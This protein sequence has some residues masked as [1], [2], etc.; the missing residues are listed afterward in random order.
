[1]PREKDV[2]LSD[3]TPCAA[4][5]W[6]NSGQP[7]STLFNDV[8]FSRTSGIK[9]K[10]Y[11]FLDGNN[12]TERIKRLSAT[13]K[14]FV[15]GETGFGT[16][17]NFLCAWQHFNQHAPE[18]ARLHFISTEKYPLSKADL[19]KALSLWPELSKYSALLLCRYLPP[20]RGFHCLKFS[21]GRITLT[22][23]IG[24]ILETLPTINAQVNA[25]F[26]DGFSP[27]KNPDMWHPSLFNTMAQ[28]SAPG[29]TYA[30]FTAAR[31]V[32]DGLLEE[33]FSVTKK[34][35][36]GCK[37]NMMCG[38]L[39]A[40]PTLI[41]KGPVW[42]QYP[43]IRPLEKSAVV[44]GGGLAGIS[45]ARALAERGWQIILLEQHSQLAMEASGN[46]QAI[47]YAKLSP[48]QT[49]LSQ[50]IA[51]GFCYSANLIRDLEAQYPNTRHG[52]GV[53]QL[54][55]SSLVRKRYIELAKQF[56]DD[57]LQYLNEY[58]LSEKA[59]MA[60]QYDG[61]FFPEAGWV[62]PSTLCYHMA[63]H[64]NITIKT[65]TKVNSLSFNSNHWQLFN[66]DQIITT[67]QTVI[68]ATGATTHL[69]AQ[70]AHLPLKGIRGQVTKRIATKTSRALRACVCAEGYVAP[71]VGDYHTLGATFDFNSTSTKLTEADHKKNVAMQSRW[72][73]AFAK[74]IGDEQNTIQDGKAGVRC[75]TPDYL[76][77]VGPIV[78][79]AHFIEQFAM[80]RKN[81]KLSFQQVPDYWPGLYI[82][83]GHGSRGLISCP[84]AGELLA[85]IINGE[86]SPVAENIREQ[87]NPNRFLVRDLARNKI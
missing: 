78:N 86:P 22:L 9:E 62:N 59:G 81:A 77:V 80:L 19:T 14:P 46:P 74:A 29:A 16:G 31:V 38:Q 20:C 18:H 54:S 57:F 17:L 21:H 32:N 4:L 49:V 53:I 36:F 68:I 48:N 82:S 65:N 85:S 84:L 39:K 79:K 51:Q 45:C 15:I 87:L 41:N 56:P 13:D 43:S 52:C 76:P 11:V 25:W 63:K 1:M 71:A 7:I 12:L 40:V 44:L 64:P 10:E 28:K 8:Y 27:A 55:T 30:T 23:I 73:P 3:T 47:L 26:L 37:R 5:K 34:K 60:I 58:Q 66:Q 35:G 75:T 67:A 70:L 24:D 50:F 2:E 69:M 33:N 83:A 61:L 42:H 72:F 6:N